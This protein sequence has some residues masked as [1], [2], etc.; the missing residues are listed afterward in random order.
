MTTAI[1]EVRELLKQQ[2]ELEEKLRLAFQR[3]FPQGSIVSWRHGLH[4]QQGKV[5]EHSDYGAT[6][7]ANNVKSGARHRLT[8]SAALWYLDHPNG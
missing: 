2:D 8:A 7:F 5:I 1:Q 6:L 4:I 3:A